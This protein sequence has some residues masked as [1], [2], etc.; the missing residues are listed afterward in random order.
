MI[1]VPTRRR[2][3]LARTLAATAA[4]VAMLAAAGPV[5]VTLLSL[6][7]IV[8]VFARRSRRGAPIPVS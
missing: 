8:A 6:S 1:R 5:L 7:L 4:G 3:R 2:R